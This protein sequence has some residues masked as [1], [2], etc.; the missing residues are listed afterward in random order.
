MTFTFILLQIYLI[1]SAMFF[2]VFLICCK[3]YDNKLMDINVKRVFRFAFT[4]IVN[5][6]FVLCTTSFLTI[7]WIEKLNQKYRAKKYDKEFDEWIRKYCNE[8]IEK[9]NY[10]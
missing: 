7:V 6:F 5:T 10:L 3:V 8:E 2:I 4:P 1:S 9:E